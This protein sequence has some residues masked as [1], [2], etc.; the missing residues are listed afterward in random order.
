MIKDDSVL[1]KYNK[2][3]NKIKKTLNKTCHSINVYD[4]KCMKNKLK[5]F[6]GAVNANFWVDKAPK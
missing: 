1:V 6:N 2:I 3:W 4:K 5:E